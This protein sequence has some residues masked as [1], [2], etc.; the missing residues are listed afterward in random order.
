MTL[1]VS[2]GGKDCECDK[3]VVLFERKNYAEVGGL[4]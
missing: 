1:L 2:K 4:E 3:E